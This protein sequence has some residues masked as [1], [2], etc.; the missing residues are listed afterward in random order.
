VDY[1]EVSEFPSPFLPFDFKVLNVGTWWAAL[2]EGNRLVNVLFL[3]F[4]ECFDA[5]IG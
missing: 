4:E 5:P 2:A 1:S 3:T